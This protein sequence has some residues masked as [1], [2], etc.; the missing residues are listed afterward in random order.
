MDIYVK[1]CAQAT[2]RENGQKH[3]EIQTHNIEKQILSV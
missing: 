3:W 2:V 1:Y